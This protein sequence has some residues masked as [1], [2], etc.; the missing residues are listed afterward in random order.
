MSDS[1]RERIERLDPYLEI[2]RDDKSYVELR[3]GLYATFFFKHFHPSVDQNESAREALIACWEDYWRFVG[4]QHQKW[5]YKFGSNV[6]GYRLPSTKVASIQDYLRDPGN[7]GNYQ[8]LV[9]GGKHEDD[10]SEYLFDLAA[11]DV[12]GAPESPYDLAYLR[13]AAPLGCVMDDRLPRFVQL[14]KRCAERLNVD[15]AHGGLGFLRT[16]NEE[17]STRRAEC[18]LSKVFSGVDIDV[19]YV[20]V[21]SVFYDLKG[22][23]LGIDSPHWLNFMNQSWVDRLGGANVLSDQLPADHFKV[24]PYEG[25]LFV[26]AGD[27]PEP[28][29]QQDGLPIAYVWLNRALR[30]IRAPEM[31]YCMGDV[32]GQLARNQDAKAY[33]TRFDAQSDQL[34]PWPDVNEKSQA[35]QPVGSPDL[36]SSNLSGLRCEAGLPCPREG[37]WFTPAA[38]DSRRHFR[39]SEVMPEIKSDYGQTIWQWDPKQN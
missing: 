18:Q 12:Y 31:S 24:E 19:P 4:P 10:A 5:G 29:H 1:Y 16:Y 3:A 34:P 22:G 11:P 32:P 2:W 37:F 38:A 26:Q 15:Q 6:K 35:I 27:R 17:S 13:L 30:P 21:S 9:H 8:Y 23:H 33:F 20:Q 25:G 39:Q 36:S 28:G 7:V 14:V